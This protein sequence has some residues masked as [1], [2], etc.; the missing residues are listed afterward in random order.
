MGAIL[1]ILRSGIVVEWL[2]TSIL[3]AGESII[4]V[5]EEKLLVYYGCGR[6]GHLRKGSGKHELYKQLQ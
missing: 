2:A 5:Q 4:V 6:R 1:K 3:K